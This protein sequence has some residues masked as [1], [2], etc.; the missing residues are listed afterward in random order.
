MIRRTSLRGKTI[1]VTVAL[2]VAFLL[3]LVAYA[4]HLYSDPFVQTSEWDVA[5][6]RF[7]TVLAVA[8]CGAFL[9][10]LFLLFLTARRMFVVLSM[11][12]L[13]VVQYIAI[14]NAGDLYSSV[15][16]DT[17]VWQ[18]GSWVPYSRL[19]Y[20]PLW[21][22]FFPVIRQPL[23]SATVPALRYYFS[24]HPDSVRRWVV[25]NQSCP[26]PFDLE[27]AAVNTLLWIFLGALAF[28]LL[29]TR[30]M[31]RGRTPPNPAAFVVGAMVLVITLGLAR[32][33]WWE[34]PRLAGTAVAKVEAARG[35]RIAYQERVEYPGRDAYAEAV[36]RLT[37]LE[38]RDRPPYSSRVALFFYESYNRVMWNAVEK[39]FGRDGLQKA[40]NEAARQSRLRQ[41]KK[42]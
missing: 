2:W 8:G 15:G 27:F 38:L 18:R 34:E 26:R 22:S 40:L 31:R 42:P 7:I 10:T 33:F 37:G 13:P 28:R 1:T 35:L 17:G 6:A 39:D 16:D 29:R 19:P 14:S 25:E 30:A 32:F 41:L 11:A 20:Y 9:C 36:R 5:H 4:V 3:V 23:W 24:R 12:F 21:V